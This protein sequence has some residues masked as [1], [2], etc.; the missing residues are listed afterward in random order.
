M[1]LRVSI[2]EKPKLKRT[3]ML[4]IGGSNRVAAVMARMLI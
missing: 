1:G 4:T 3:A 2:G